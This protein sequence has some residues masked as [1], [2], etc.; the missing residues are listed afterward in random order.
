MRLIG[1]IA[2]CDGGSSGTPTGFASRRRPSALLAEWG[3]CRWVWNQCVAE[4]RQAWKD[5]RECGPAGLDK[6]LTG[7]RA[8]HGWLR[9]G[10]SVAQKQTIRDF[11]KARA[12]ALK[13]RKNKVPVHQRAGLPQ[14]RKRDR[15]APTMNY[16]RQGFT[17]R[18]GQLTLAGGIS[19]R[20]VWSRP[21]P[22]VPSS[23][24]VYRDALGNWHASFVV[25]A[26]AE[27]YPATGQVIG[28]DWGVK[29]IATTTSDAHDLPHPGYGKKSAEKLGR[30][31]RQMARRKRKPGQAASAGYKRAKR[32][33]AKAHMKVAAQRRDTARKWAR[34]VVRD[35]DVIA[36]EDFRPKFLAKSTMAKKAADAAIGSAKAALL[37]VAAKHGRVIHMV[38]P[39]YTTMDCS[40]CGARAKSRLPLSERTFRCSA[41]GLV[42]PRDKNSAAVMLNRA[43]LTPAGADRVRRAA[44]Q[45]Q[46]AP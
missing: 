23:V 33:A 3:R 29:E 11:G 4:S 9:E 1:A 46:H 10:S 37:H 28:I 44:A 17:L 2:G 12:K 18:D 22:S 7:W 38:D 19:L 15:V 26:Q 24:R 20:V 25:Q 41:C 31:Q 30:Y 6:M 45:P 36:V 27:P 35:H 43:G 42:L 40:R 34:A 14:F 13:V 39:T 21:L 5:G 32:K 16:T 8:E